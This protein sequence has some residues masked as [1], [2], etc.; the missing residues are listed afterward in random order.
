VFVKE[1]LLDTDLEGGGGM[2]VAAPTPLALTLTGTFLNAL[3]KYDKDDGPQTHML[4]EDCKSDKELKKDLFSHARSPDGLLH[5]SLRLYA[6][7]CRR[8][9]S[10]PTDQ[11]IVESYFNVYDVACRPKSL[12]ET[13]SSLLQLRQPKEM[14]KKL[15]VEEQLEARRQVAVLHTEQCTLA[16]HTAHHRQTHA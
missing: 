15:T 14:R 16:L 11:Q 12:A 5:M 1:G 2:E 9:F 13:N 3:K 10:C 6:W 7:V 8:V 4:L